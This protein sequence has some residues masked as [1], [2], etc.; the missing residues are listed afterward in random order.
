MF[1][2]RTF[3]VVCA[4]TALA[5]ILTACGPA[6]TPTTEAT[7][8][9]T[10]AGVVF[11][12]DQ[13]MKSMVQGYVDAG[14]KYGIK[15]LTANTNNDQAK[16]A[17]LIQ[18]YI[19]QK[20]SG[21]AIAPL[22]QDASIPNLKEAA[23]SGIQVAITNMNLKGD[24]SF[25]AGGY[26]SDDTT[27][28]KIVGTNAAEFI[29]ANI[30][31]D[32]NIAQVDFDDQVPEQSKARWGGFFAGLDEAGVKYTK[33]ATVSS[34]VQDDAITKVSDMLTANPEINIIWACNDGSTIGAAMAVQQAG[35][36][37]KVFVFGYDGGDQQTSMILS[38][39]NI[40]VGVVSQD[41]YTQ[42]YKAVESLALTL[43]GK[44]NPDAGKITVVPGMYLSSDDPTGVNAWR[45]ANG[46]EEI[47]VGEPEA[48]KELVVAGVVFQDDQFMKSMVQGYEDAGAK[49]GIKIMTANTNNDQAK[50]AELIQT[51][52]AQ[53]VSGIAIAPLSQDAS[54]PNLKEATSKG[55]QVAI[56]NLNLAGDPSWLAGGYTSDDA[57]NG[58]IV[59]TN[60]AE[61]IKANITGPINVAQVDFDHQIP[62]QSKARYDGF[63]AGLDE[64]GTEYTKVAAVSANMQDD[65]LTK[66]TDMLTAHPEIN[67][68][69]AC[70]D[71]GT[72]GAAMAVQQAGLAGKVFVFGYDGGDQQTSMMFGEN[73]I[74][75]GVVTQDPYQ[76]GYKAVESLALTL[77]EQANP[78][79]GKITVV[80]G[81]Y[82]SVSDLDGVKKWRK[83]NGLK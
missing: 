65:A 72:I 75:I 52:I 24:P 46:L 55:I 37:G 12:D 74:L 79:A 9:L 62:E 70:N 22:S 43:Q 82:L 4:I 73:P 33:V 30:T 42:G 6:A 36:A 78:D 56:T 60:A 69:W 54:I 39:D 20:V 83:D 81:T 44:A 57:T 41:P 17:E 34:H 66:V 50:E 63:Y 13:F 58:K 15:I 80:P 5:M 26:T 68:I 59:G 45:K 31:G 29:K 61:F 19:A 2:N 23:T 28:G 7:T 8:E 49:Y 10:V 11:Q 40:L 76:Q 21:I 53:G 67:V 3:L 25:L 18:T 38:S 14:A 64:A 32:V 71:G 51:Y 16:E 27:N 77:L 35:L 47:A 48:P 1:K